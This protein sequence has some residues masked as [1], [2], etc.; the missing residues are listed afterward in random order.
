[1]L[2]LIN[3]L[4]RFF[5]VVHSIAN[6]S[7]FFF[8]VLF[9][10]T[11]LISCALVSHRSSS[12]LLPHLW[13]PICFCYHSWFTFFRFFC[14]LS[15]VFTFDSFCF[16]FSSP[17]FSPLK[18]VMFF[19]SLLNVECIGR[20]RIRYFS[21]YFSF[22]A[23]FAADVLLSLLLLLVCAFVIIKIIAL[24]TVWYRCSSS[25]SNINMQTKN[26]LFEHYFVPHRIDCTFSSFLHFATIYRFF[27]FR[28]TFSFAVHTAPLDFD[29]S[30]VISDQIF[31]VEKS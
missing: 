30:P 9:A 18:L 10:L 6:F 15:V 23:L 24:M 2:S 25:T 26:L 5:F 29:Q 31:F 20:A 16:T 12:V 3:F 14:F 19:S 22:C 17:I 28:L 21:I 11:F 27:V 1:M 8:F 7:L 13:L 4:L